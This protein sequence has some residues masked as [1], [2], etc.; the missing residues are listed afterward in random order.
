[1]NY[2]ILDESEPMALNDVIRLL[3]MTYWADERTTEQVKK[4][5]LTLPLEDTV[6]SNQ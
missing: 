2:R 6:S 1:M 3:K 4:S 5:P